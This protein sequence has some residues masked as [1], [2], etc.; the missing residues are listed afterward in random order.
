MKRLL[1]LVLVLPSFVMAQE[2]IGNKIYKYGDVYHSIVGA[3]LVSFDEAKA[4]TM[5][6]TLEYFS[7]AGAKNIQSYTSVFLPG[8]EVSENTFI[9]TLDKRNI[10]TLIVIDIIDASQASMSR[11]TTSGFASAN[12]KREK[13]ISS[14]DNGWS[15]K[16]KG[17]STSSSTSISTTKNV[18]FVTELN[19]RLTIFSKNDGFSAPVAVV[20]GRATNESPDT[21]PDQMA[22]RI[23]RRMVKALDK[24]RAF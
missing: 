20:E 13:S 1:L 12:Q 4:K 23:V 21:T 16:S 19:L 5:S 7:D 11:T 17:K 18:D 15:S 2:K 10:Q 3:T 24:Q 9:G 8:T 6:K 14:T 22:R